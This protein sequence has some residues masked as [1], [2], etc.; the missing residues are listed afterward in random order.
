MGV[1][2]FTLFISGGFDAD[3]CHL[4]MVQFGFGLYLPCL[5]IDLQPVMFISFQF[6]SKQKQQKKC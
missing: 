4:L 3:H 1:N 6:V 2:V 5:C